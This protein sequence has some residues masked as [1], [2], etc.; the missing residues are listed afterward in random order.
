MKKNVNTNNKE[1]IEALHLVRKHAVMM[2]ES[3]LKSDLGRFSEIMNQGWIH[4]KKVA[5]GITNSRIDK[6]YDLAIK[7]GASAG[8]VSGAGGGGFMLF[9]CEPSKRYNLINQLNDLGGQIR[10]YQFVKNG[11]VTWK[12]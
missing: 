7:S 2:K 12:A 8:R 1:S 6:V 3:I 5:K 4:K 9:F 11:L 10:G